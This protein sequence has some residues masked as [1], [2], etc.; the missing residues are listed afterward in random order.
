MK[1]VLLTIFFIRFLYADESV[2]LAKIHYEKGLVYYKNNEVERAKAEWQ[3]SLEFCKDYEHSIKALKSLEEEKFIENPNDSF[4]KIIKDFFEKGLSYYRTG[5]FKKAVEE[6]DKALELSPK[7]NQILTFIEKTKIKNEVEEVKK[8]EKS[9]KVKEVREVEETKKVVEEKK[10][11]TVKNPI[12]EKKVSELYYAGLKCYK[13]GKI[14]EAI[15]LWKQVL[16]LDPNNEKAK[17]N[18]EKLEK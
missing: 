3:K 6:W 4:N 1:I 9:E 14:S 7:N 2:D 5:D 17:K 15:E 16:K 18:L 8:V 10:T 13:Q 12:D 11:K